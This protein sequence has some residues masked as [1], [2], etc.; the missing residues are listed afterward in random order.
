MADHVGDAAD[1]LGE[2]WVVG[3]YKKA[4]AVWIVRRFD[5]ADSRGRGF[6]VL[7]P[8]PLE[9]ARGAAGRIPRP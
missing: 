3:Q 9:A 5:K 8:A 4:L 2:T 7:T 6:D 1:R